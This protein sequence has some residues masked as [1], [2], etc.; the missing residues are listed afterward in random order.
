VCRVLLAPTR[1]SS[2]L[3][4]ARLLPHGIVIGHVQRLHTC[5]V[6]HASSRKRQNEAQ[7]GRAP[8]PRGHEPAHH[9]GHAVVMPRGRR[10][11]QILHVLATHS[12]SASRGNS[13][14]LRP[15][16]HTLHAREPSLCRAGPANSITCPAL[17][18]T[19]SDRSAD[20]W[21]LKNT[22]ERRTVSLPK[23]RSTHL[24]V[25]HRVCNR[26]TPPS[27]VTHSF[28][29]IPARQR[30]FQNGRGQ[31]RPGCTAAYRSL[32][33]GP[34]T[35]IQRVLQL[36]ARTP[37]LSESPGDSCLATSVSQQ[38]VASIFLLFY[39]IFSPAA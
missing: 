18:S 22:G 35:Q 13:T 16:T 15:P 9:S 29:F 7:D 3:L 11:L 27:V 32:R 19:R 4:S 24:I 28:K 33:P 17:T 34:T 21:R 12:K 30:P 31:M 10:R 1:F 39:S 8:N 38:V 25:A 5:A 37:V 36:P 23:L 14:H 6:T 2:R 26:E 20:R